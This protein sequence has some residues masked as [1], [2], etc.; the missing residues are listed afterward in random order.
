[1]DYTK[2]QAARAAAILTTGEVAANAFLTEKSDN[3]ALTVEL[4]FTIGSLTNVIVKFYGSAD[5]TNYYAVNEP[6]VGL[7]ETLTGSVNKY[8]TFPALPG[9]KRFRVS[10]TGTGTA[11]NS[12]ATVNYYY[13][14]RGSQR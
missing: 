6:Y 2:K 5:G 3:G 12:T 4:K 8:Y 11:T 9:L 14:Q 1:M 13:F 10:L 7:S